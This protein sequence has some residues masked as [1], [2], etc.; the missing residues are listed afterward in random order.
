MDARTAATR[1]RQ[2]CGNRSSRA[3]QQNRKRHHDPFAP[4]K[5]QRHRGQQDGTGDSDDGNNRADVDQI[6]DSERRDRIARREVVTR[7]K[8]LGW[9]AGQQ[10]ER[11]D[12][13]D[14]IAGEKRGERLSS[15][16]PLAA[17]RTQ[18]PRFGAN[19][20]TESG[21]DQDGNQS[22]TDS[23]DTLDNFGDAGAASRP[24]KKEQAAQRRREREYVLATP[25]AHE[26]RTSSDAALPAV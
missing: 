14:R 5:R 2:I 7:Q 12:V 24:G 17:R 26:E 25:G 16:Q 20:E 11:C 23:A 9:F 18:A 21:Q 4:G 19:D 15:R 13:A 1:T 3:E 6:V 8:H 22:P 10:S